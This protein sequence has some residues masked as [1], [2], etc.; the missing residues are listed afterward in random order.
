VYRRWA[1]KDALVRAALEQSM[2][3]VRQVPDTGALHSDLAELSA[4]VAGF[5]TSP[6]G[7]AVFRTVFADGHTPRARKLAASMWADAG[8]VPRVIV[9]RAIA[10]GELPKTADV[11]L[12]LFT[13]AGAL[14][15]RV[16]VEH[17]PVDDAYLA[18]LVRLVT[19]GAAGR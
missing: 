18:R 14:M 11:E 8:D 7:T 17:A 2:E 19:F 4:L 13:L 12:L 9:E 6:R 1:T 15:H 16:F 3:H 5:I 10:R